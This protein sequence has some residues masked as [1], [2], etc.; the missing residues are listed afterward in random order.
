MIKKRQKHNYTS[1]LELKSLIIRTNNKKKSIGTLQYNTI[2]NKYIKLFVKLNNMKYDKPTKKN[3]VKAKLKS[4]IISLSEMT[5][6][7]TLSYENFGGIIMLMIKNILKKPQFSGYT[8]RD[9]FYSDAIYKIIKYM[10]NFKHN[11]ISKITNQ[12]V[13]SFAY[14]S[15]IIHN[16]I[17]FII[18]TK[19]AE[20]DKLKKHIG[21]EAI[22]SQYQLKTDEIFNKS[23]FIDED[24]EHISIVIESL[25][26]TSLYDYIIDNESEYIN[27]IYPDDYSISFEEYEKLKEVLKCKINIIKNRGDEDEL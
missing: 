18:N 7:D 1:E 24:E 16:S 22:N 21:M 13:N 9:D 12:P 5:A 27:Y 10:H 17:I 6:I 2:I 11:M 25:D 15:Q 8:Y 23:T 4:R 14:I 20:N 3:K 19:K 26:G